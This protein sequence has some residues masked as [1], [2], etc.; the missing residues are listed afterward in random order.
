MW[1]FLPLVSPIPSAVVAQR[2]HVQM[3]EKFRQNASPLSLKL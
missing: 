2:I 1:R 3:A